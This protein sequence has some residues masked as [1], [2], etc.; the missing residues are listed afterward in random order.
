MYYIN[1]EPRDTPPGTAAITV[2]AETSHSLKYQVPHPVVWITAHP[3]AR[4]VGLTIGHDQRVHDLEAF[5]RLLINA[6]TW[7][8][9]R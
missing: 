5:Q 9:R 2:L 1:A 7:A 4:V 8:S 6:V 3:T